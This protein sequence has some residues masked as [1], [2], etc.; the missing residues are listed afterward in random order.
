MEAITITCQEFIELLELQQENEPFNFSSNRW[1]KVWPTPGPGYTPENKREY[2][3]RGAYPKLDE[4]VSIV[5]RE[6]YDAGRFYLTVYGVYLSKGRR[7]IAEFVF[8]D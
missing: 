4:I 6:R 2:V 5:M 8:L 7:Q 1:G 3:E